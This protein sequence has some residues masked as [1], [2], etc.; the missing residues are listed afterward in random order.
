MRVKDCPE[1]LR[2]NKRYDSLFIGSENDEAAEIL[3][4]LFRFGFGFPIDVFSIRL[5]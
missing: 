4:R 2:L 5:T 1:R 3:S